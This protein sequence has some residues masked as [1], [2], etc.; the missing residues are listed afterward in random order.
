MKIC[1]RRGRGRRAIP[2]LAADGLTAVPLFILAKKRQNELVP[3]RASR[4]S[5]SGRLQKLRKK[6]IVIAICLGIGKLVSD[7]REWKESSSAR[8]ETNETLAKIHS[9]ISYAD[10]HDIVWHVYRKADCSKVC[11]SS[12]FF[13]PSPLCMS[14]GLYSCEGVVVGRQRRRTAFRAVYSCCQIKP[15][16]HPFQVSLKL[17]QWCRRRFRWRLT[18]NRLAASSNGPA[19]T[20]LLGKCIVVRIYEGFNGIWS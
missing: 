16:C 6:L 15:S 7:E 5:T 8:T 3:P 18:Q 12:W 9:G 11:M 13:R 4:P 1:T 10:R 20:A 2:R 19:R 14:C 17:S